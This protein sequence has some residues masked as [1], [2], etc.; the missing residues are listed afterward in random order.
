M[1]SFSTLYGSKWV[2]VRSAA[3]NFS[4]VLGFSTLYGSKWVAAMRGSCSRMVLSG[5]STLYGSKWVAVGLVGWDDCR[6][7]RFQYPL[8][9]EVGCRSVCHTE[10]V[11]LRAFQYPLRVEVGC[12]WLAWGFELTALTVSVPSTGRSGLQLKPQRIRFIRNS[13]FSTLYGS[14]WVAE[15]FWLPRNVE[16]H[17]SV[18]STGRSGLQQ[19]SERLCCKSYTVSVPSTGRSGLQYLVLLPRQ[20]QPTEFQ[21]PL[22]VEVGCRAVT[23]AIIHAM[24]SFSTLYGSKWVAALLCTDQCRVPSKF[25]Y[26]LRVEVGCSAAR[27][28]IYPSSLVFQYPLRVEVGCRVLPQSYSGLTR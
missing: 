20:R 11:A 23:A 6:R 26:P 14:K 10:F 15:D 7:G 17:V 19:I 25:Q 4:L 21:Y 22:R 27:I 9:V 8:R 12:S 5:F 1:Y 13:G 18:P 28:T 2:A 3:V 16:L 24:L